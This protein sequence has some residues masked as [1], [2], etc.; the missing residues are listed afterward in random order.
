MFYTK[1]VFEV[2]QRNSK[3][4]I[5]ITPP[6][7]TKLNPNLPRYSENYLKGSPGYNPHTNSWKKKRKKICHTVENTSELL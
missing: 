3:N 4:Y 6:I 7:F 2:K 5:K 1:M